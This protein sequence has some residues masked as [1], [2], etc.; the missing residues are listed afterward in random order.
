MNQY[1]AKIDG[2]VDLLRLSQQMS[3][4]VTKLQKS[5]EILQQVV[6]IDT[7]VEDEIIFKLNTLH[8]LLLH[9]IPDTSTLQKKI[10]IYKGIIGHRSDVDMF[11]TKLPRIDML[12]MY[13]ERSDEY[14]EKTQELNKIIVDRVCPV[15]NSIVK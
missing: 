11:K 6:E 14:K 9:E 10:E 8:S 3:K 4:G 5:V 15:C 12:R 2:Y 7:S 13:I 1:K